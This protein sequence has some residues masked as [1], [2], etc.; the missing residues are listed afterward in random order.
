MLHNLQIFHWSRLCITSGGHKK[1]LKI[2]WDSTFKL[3]HGLM[4]GFWS[5]CGHWPFAR[6]MVFSRMPLTLSS[7]LDE[8]RWCV[9]P[10]LHLFLWDQRGLPSLSV[11]CSPKSLWIMLVALADVSR[12]TARVYTLLPSRAGAMAALK[13]LVVF[14]GLKCLLSFV[15]LKFSPASRH[16]R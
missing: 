8:G 14:F 15:C 16:H 4:F 13:L 10:L 5:V 1:A 12:A 11:S 7:I 9:H 3:L 2:W 6:V